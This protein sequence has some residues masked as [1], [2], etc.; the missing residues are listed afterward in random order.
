MLDRSQQQQPGTYSDYA[1]VARF[2]DPNIDQ[3][4]VVAVGIGRGARSRPV[5]FWWTPS[6]GRGAESTDRPI[7]E[8]KNVEIVLETQVIRDRSGP[9]RVSAVYVW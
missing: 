6:H 4:V 8:R 5:S 3:W 9:P 2:I 1:L 7:G